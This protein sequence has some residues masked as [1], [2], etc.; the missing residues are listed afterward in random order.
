[1]DIRASI[2]SF[3][4]NSQIL[5]MEELQTTCGIVY[6]IYLESEIN[7]KILRVNKDGEIETIREW[8]RN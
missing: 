8:V 3:Y 2:K 1:M 5:M 6:V 4:L 7:M